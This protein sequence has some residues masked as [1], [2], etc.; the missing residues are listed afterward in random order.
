M[1]MIVPC[2]VKKINE[3]GFWYEYLYQPLII[4]DGVNYYL[5]KSPEYSLEVWYGENKYL[6]ENSEYVFSDKLSGEYLI[7]PYDKVLYQ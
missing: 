7:V 1:Y 5:I 3:G 2:E 4:E 6:F